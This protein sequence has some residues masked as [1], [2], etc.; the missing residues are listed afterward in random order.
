MNKPLT[1]KELPE[2]ERPRE[3]MLSLGPAILTDSELIAVILGIGYRG[4]SAVHL[5]ESLLAKA[6]GLRGLFDLS[7]EEMQQQSGIG[8][9]K[10][11]QLV[12]VT[13]LAARIASSRE[14]Q[15]TIKQPEDVARLLMPRYQMM[16]HEEFAALLLDTKNKVL[17]IETISKGSLNASIVHPREVFK[18]AIRRSAAAII[19]T[20]NHPSGD[21]SPSREDIDVTRRLSEAGKI[22]GIEVLDHIIFGDGRT[23]SMKEKGLV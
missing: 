16:K 22:I 8:L 2:H 1:I 20:H 23:V 12:A 17:A 5:A 10:S 3:R 21:P 9:A 15:I 11:C 7:L 4:Q 13:E 18:T 6:G 19:V 14:Q